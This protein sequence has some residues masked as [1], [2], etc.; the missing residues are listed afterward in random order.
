MFWVQVVHLCIDF[1]QF[2]ILEVN[3]V[4]FIGLFVELELNM[5]EFQFLYR[6]IVV[7][8]VRDFLVGCGQ[9]GQGILLCVDFA[10]LIFAF[11]VKLVKAQYPLN[12]ASTGVINSYQPMEG[13]VAG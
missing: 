8:I 10:F 5:D 11:D 7:V 3:E 6:Y 13:G 1:V 2:D 4:D 12:E 9:A